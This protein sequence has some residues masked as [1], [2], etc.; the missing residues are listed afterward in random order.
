[1][2]KI[3]FNRNCL[4]QMTF[5]NGF[6]ISLS[7]TYGSYSSNRNIPYNEISPNRNT[8]ETIEVACWDEEEDGTFV[9]LSPFDDVVGY[10][11][12][13]HVAQYIAIVSQARS[14][15]EIKEKVKGLGVQG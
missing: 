11:K 12:A 13:D 10:V 1:M 8:V 2:S 9:P 4:F 5:E 14:V 15:E 7:S 3:V 6:S